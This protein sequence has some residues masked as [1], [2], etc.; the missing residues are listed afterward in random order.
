MFL[1]LIPIAAALVVTAASAQSGNTYAEIGGVY[2]RYEE[3][4]AWFTSGVVNVKLGVN[5]NESVAIEAM[6]GKSLSDTNFYAGNTRVS[7]RI[8][9]MV[10]GF[11]KLKA[12]LS[13]DVDIFGRLGYTQGKISANSRFG[14]GWSSGSSVSY[15]GGLQFN[16]SATS[17]VNLDYMSYFSGSGVTVNGIG[18]NVGMK[19]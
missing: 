2:A 12:P 4:G 14:S 10:S 7:A 13:R 17:Y 5:L 1:K 16:T 15:G 19:F 8:D 9:S 11:V 6:V 3:P 18:A